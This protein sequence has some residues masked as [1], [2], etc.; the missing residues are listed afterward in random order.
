ML[1]KT[2]VEIEHTI[3]EEVTYV[4]CTIESRH[5]AWFRPHVNDELKYEGTSVYFISGG[6][7]IIKMSYS[8][9]DSRML[10]ATLKK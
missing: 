4:P 2:E 9:F 6:N 1:I 10:T 3:T 8:D 7:C 5:V